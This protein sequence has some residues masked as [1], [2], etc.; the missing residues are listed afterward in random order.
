MDYFFKNNR[1]KEVKF[2]SSPVLNLNGIKETCQQ[3]KLIRVL[4]NKCLRAALSS[5]RSKLVPL[6][7]VF[8]VQMV[9][10]RKRQEN[11]YCFYKLKRE[12]NAQV[13]RE[14]IR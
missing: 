7:S 10:I 12:T 3:I 8:E 9:E 1:Q 5:K 2:I 11:T 6:K 13:G 4:E 14:A